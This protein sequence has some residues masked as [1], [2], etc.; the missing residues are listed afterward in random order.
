MP[1]AL[2]VRRVVPLKQSAGGGE[3]HDTFAHGSPLHV[4]P[5]QPKAQVVSFEVYWHAP[6]AQLP[7]DQVRRVE[8]LTQLEAGGW[9][10]VIVDDV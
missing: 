4:V 1:V 10:H 2:Y 3:V 8:L 7:P 5:L 6:L 9:L